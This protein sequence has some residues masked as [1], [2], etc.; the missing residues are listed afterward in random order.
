MAWLL[1]VTAASALSESHSQQKQN[2]KH[3]GRSTLRNR[4]PLAGP[5]GDSSLHT[6]GWQQV[7]GQTTGPDSV[8]WEKR[9]HQGVLMQERGIKHQELILVPSFQIYRAKPLLQYTDAILGLSAR[10]S[11]HLYNLLLGLLEERD[12]YI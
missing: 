4:A 11:S 8:T 5:S 2:Y 10:K 3:A 7:R 12:L 9:H 6:P 1:V